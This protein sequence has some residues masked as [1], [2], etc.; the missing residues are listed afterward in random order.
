MTGH[1]LSEYV[2]P[3]IGTAATDLPERHGLA[4]RWFSLKA[5]AP[6]DHP[7]ATSAF[8]LMTICPYSR[9]YPTGYGVLGHNT[10]GNRSR[11]ALRMS[12]LWERATSACS[13]T[14]SRP[15][16]FR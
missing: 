11:A 12:G 7:G 1:D 10:H 9:A 2:D 15:T 3:F 13:I 14:S 5:Q 16:R 4:A 6:N 8:G